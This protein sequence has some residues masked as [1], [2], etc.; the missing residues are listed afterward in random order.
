MEIVRN[1]E[2][3]IIIIS[4]KDCKNEQV[5][6]EKL[7]NNQLTYVSKFKKVYLNSTNHSKQFNDDC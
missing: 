7:F 4:R 5:F 6:Y 2:G 3:N 1:K